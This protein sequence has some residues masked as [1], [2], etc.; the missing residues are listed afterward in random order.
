MQRSGR[1]NLAAAVS[2]R[3]LL[4]HNEATPEVLD[5]LET[6]ILAERR[7]G[8]VTCATRHRE[9]DEAFAFTYVEIHDAAAQR[10]QAVEMARVK[11]ETDIRVAEK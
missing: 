1:A 3:L 11:K 6:R 9:S 2:G 8:K 7:L 10:R 5:A 4:R